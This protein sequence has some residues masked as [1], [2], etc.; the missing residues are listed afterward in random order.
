M[1]KTVKKLL[2]VF[3]LILM[4]VYIL[5]IESIPSKLVIFEGENIVLNTLLGLNVKFNSQTIETASNYQ[6][7]T[8]TTSEKQH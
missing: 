8:R 6:E 4:Y 7:I 3:V 5:S 1:K 2:L